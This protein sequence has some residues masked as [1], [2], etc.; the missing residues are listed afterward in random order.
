MTKKHSDSTNNS[1]SDDCGKLELQL[2]MARKMIV[3][4]CKNIKE[5]E[6][7][8]LLKGFAD[9]EKSSGESVRT[10]FHSLFKDLG[11]ISY[12][13]ELGKEDQDEEK[14]IIKRMEEV[15]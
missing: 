6:F 1:T 4:L 8:C 14:D 5:P 7:L 3:Y 15:S 2:E 13:E 12:E 10:L 11:I 9:E